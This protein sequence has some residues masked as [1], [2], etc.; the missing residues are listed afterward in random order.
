MNE[1]T[2]SPGSYEEW[3]QSLK[4]RI[5]GAQLRA[6][7][8]VN[9]ELVLLYWQIGREIL[10]RQ[11]RHGWGAKVVERLA[12]DLRRAFPDQKGFSPRNLKYMRAFAEAWPDE[13]FV[14]QVAAQ[15]PWFHN[16]VLLE[17]LGDPERRAWYARQAIEHGWSRAILAHQI[18]SGLYERQGRALTNFDRTLPPARSDLARQILKDPYRFD[19]LGLGVEAQE[20]DLEHALLRHI[21]E[22]LIELGLGFAFVGSQYHMVVADQDY[23]LDMLFYHLKLR[24]YVVIDLKIGEFKPEDA[25]KMNFYLSAAD[26]ML[27]HADDQPSIGVILCKSKSQVIVEYTL[28]DMRKPI[29]VSEYQLTQALPQYLQ[30]SLP[31]I[32]ELEAALTDPTLDDPDAPMPLA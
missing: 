8:A 25:G 12:R 9:R 17:K 29:G 4:E 2:A 1:L 24:C 30:T 18:D 19:F 31:T 15:I 20:R 5:A 7:L 23:Y 27:R 22:F 28:R 13:A 26:E 3:L 21:R 14:Q 6:A 32:E 11:R 16:C 10:D